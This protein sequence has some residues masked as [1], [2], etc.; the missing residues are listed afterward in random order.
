MQYHIDIDI[1]HLYIIVAKPRG[2]RGSM[3][4]LFYWPKA[5][6]NQGNIIFIT[7]YKNRFVVH[8]LMIV[9]MYNVYVYCI[10]LYF[11]ITMMYF[12]YLI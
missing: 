2:Q 4:N 1:H 7:L 12:H 6:H 10:L 8:T 11:Y 3:A 5:F 9:D